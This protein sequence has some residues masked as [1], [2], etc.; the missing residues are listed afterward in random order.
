MF[1][2]KIKNKLQFGIV[3]N[4]EA[5]MLDS[6]IQFFGMALANKFLEILAIHK[7]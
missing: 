3:L 4:N 1:D 6:F 7:K 5:I 2:S